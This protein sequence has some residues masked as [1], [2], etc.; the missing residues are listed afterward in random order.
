V[1]WREL[2][3]NIQGV[4]REGQGREGGRKGRGW[5]DE[6][7]RE[8]KKRVRRELRRWWKRGGEVESYRKVKREYNK[9]CEKKKKGEN[10]RW[11]EMARKAK[12]EGQVWE[13]VNRERNGWNISRR[14]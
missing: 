2:R 1:D 6:E 12:T 3:E 13:V 14:R 10:E 9:M 4:L 11:E 5:W 8:G 7:C